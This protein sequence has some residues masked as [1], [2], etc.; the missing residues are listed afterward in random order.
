MPVTLD[1][2][3]EA[4]ALKFCALVNFMVREGGHHAAFG[5]AG[6]VHKTRRATERRHMRRMSTRGEENAALANMRECGE[7]VADF[8]VQL[9]THKG[10]GL[11]KGGSKWHRRRISVD[12]SSATLV[13]MDYKK[14][15]KQRTLPS[16]QFP[17]DTRRG[18]SNG[19]AY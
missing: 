2:A 1:L 19:K 7:L 15:G 8:D 4:D 13:L 9:F 18:M 5:D 11:L 6:S 10:G 17:Q 16:F 3:S 14:P 12:V